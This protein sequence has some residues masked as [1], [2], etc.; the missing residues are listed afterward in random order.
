MD[1]YHRAPGFKPMFEFTAT[2]PAPTVD[3]LSVMAYAII[4]DV[5]QDAPVEH[6]PEVQL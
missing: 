2:Q 1:L 6:Q 5:V 3:W 4:A